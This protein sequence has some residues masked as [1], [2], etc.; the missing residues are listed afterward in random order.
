MAE[1][2]LVLGCGQPDGVGGA[3]AIRFANDG[4]HLL[5]TGRT[6]A[7][8]E[9]TVEAIRASGGT[10]EALR[11]DVT[12]EADE[13]AACARVAAMGQ[14]LGAVVYNAGA[15]NPMAFK[16][17]EAAQFE[18]IWRIGC[19]GGFHAAKR[20]LPVFE[21]QARGTLIFTG[22][23]ASLRGKAGYAQFA[24]AKGALRNLAQSPAREYGPRGIHIAHVI[25]DGVVN[26]ERA[27][28]HFGDYLGKLGDDGA[29]LPSA[30][31]EAF[32]VLHN[33]HRSAWTHELD[34]RPFSE[35]W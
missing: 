11:V 12:E 28:T 25:I 8:L 4:Y 30:I 1:T 14:P 17:I 21:R 35:N 29:L 6:P 23:S 31:A 13:D 19:L 15:N 26:G 22:A 32:V 10:A 9:L 18:E 24:S 16:D 5:V 34:L 3:T 2:V 27:Q 20:A 7:K 33:Q